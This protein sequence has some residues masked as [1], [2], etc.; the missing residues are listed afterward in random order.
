[1]ELIASAAGLG[2]AAL[3]FLRARRRALSDDASS[4]YSPH[5][6]SGIGSQQSA[7]KEHGRRA[8]SGLDHQLYWMRAQSR[9]SRRGGR[10]DETGSVD[11]CDSSTFTGEVVILRTDTFTG[12]QATYVTS[13]GGASKKPALYKKRGVGDG[14]HV[15]IH[16][17]P[18]VVSKSTGSKKDCPFCPGSEHRC[19]ADLARVDEGGAWV[20][21]APGEAG[22]WA[23][24]PGR[25]KLRVL[26]N[27]FPTMCCPTAAGSGGS[28]E[29]E[30]KAG[31]GGS[32]SMKRMRPPTWYGSASDAQ[33]GG[34]VGAAGPDGS[35][36]TRPSPF[37]LSALGETD[38]SSTNPDIHH[39]RQV[40]FGPGP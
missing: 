18:A 9:R 1:M 19:P 21:H 34:K 26:R 28:T 6:P 7:A 3:A 32:H 8:G 38:N 24:G 5:A 33:I 4:T 40:Y 10:L 15:P 25:W 13:A 22:S 12:E 35:P 27:T 39:P 17:L 14:G 37:L 36:L 16:M 23:A 2:L 29:G 11:T 31:A 20:V 30:E